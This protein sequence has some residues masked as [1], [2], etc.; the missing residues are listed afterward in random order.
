M[1]LS[2]RCSHDIAPSLPF[3]TFTLPIMSNLPPLSAASHAI[4]ESVKQKAMQISMTG[5]IE[6]VLEGYR[7]CAG[8]V[9]NN[10]LQLAGA[11]EPASILAEDAIENLRLI[12]NNLS[13]KITP[14]L[15]MR[16]EGQKILSILREDGDSN[17]SYDSYLDALESLIDQLTEDE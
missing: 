11:N 17:E 12:A 10:A 15:S 16:Y 7:E 6:K 3:F 8:L 4:V 9:L 13:P 1:N 5:G 14:K 2:R